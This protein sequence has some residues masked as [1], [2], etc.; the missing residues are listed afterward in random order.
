MKDL[1]W[2]A[3]KKKKTNKKNPPFSLK[4][5][6]YSNYYNKKNQSVLVH[7]NNVINNVFKFSMYIGVQRPF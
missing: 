3:C 6:E 1:Q 2:T 7:L 4:I 5:Y